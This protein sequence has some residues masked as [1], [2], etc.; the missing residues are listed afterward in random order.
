[1]GRIVDVS[2]GNPVSATWGNGIR[3]AAVMQVLASEVSSIVGVEGQLI[4]VSDEDR[5]K[6]YDGSAWVRVGWGATS[7]GRTGWKGRRVASQSISASTMTDISFDTEDFDSDGYLVPTAATFTIP[8]GLGG[9]YVA[10]VSVTWA[11]NPTQ[12]STSASVAFHWT[13]GGVLQLTESESVNGNIYTSAGIAYQ[14]VSAFKSV[15]AGDTLSVKVYNRSAGAV[16]VTCPQF[17]LYR[18]GV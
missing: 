12:A 8:T 13:I 4:Y 10:S 9:L 3:D 7:T 18:I 14:G 2:A 6:V 16:N 5:F 15:A 17:E 11:S 1:M